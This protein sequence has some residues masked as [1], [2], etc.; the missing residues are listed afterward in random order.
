MF[1]N[2][3]RAE[4]IMHEYGLD[5]LLASTLQNVFYLSGFWNENFLITP[6]SAQTYVLT[7]RSGLAEPSV[8]AS[9]G[10]AAAVLTA[11]PRASHFTLFGSFSR[12]QAPGVEPEGVEH[13]LADLTAPGSVKANSMEALEAAFTGRALTTGVVGYDERG[14]DEKLLTLLRARLPKVD[15]RPADAIFIRLRAVKTPEEVR[16]LESAVALTEAAVRAVIGMISPG[17]TEAEMV[18][19]FERTIVSGGGRPYFSQIYAG[20]RGSVGQQ[21]FPDGVVRRGDIVRFDVGCVF[22][23]YCSDIAR[24]VAVGDPGDRLRRL[25]AATVAAEDAALEALRPGARASDV[26]NAGVD[27]ARKTLPNYRRQHIGHGV[28]LEVYEMPLLGPNDHTVVEEGM[29]LEV[30]TPYYEIGSAG[31]QPEDT[32]VVTQGSPRIIN[33]LPRDLIVVG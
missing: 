30:E 4:A 11:C 25:H 29:T 9:V 8:I 26:F 21:P 24:N 20:R 12:Y 10:D 1:L 31:L 2:E 23:G 7:P 16:R 14:M 3:P 15:F 22:K 6:R 19:E 33:T 13:R 32:V 27:A 17:V 5:A 18:R 28:G